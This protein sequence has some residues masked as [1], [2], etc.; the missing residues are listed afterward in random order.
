VGAGS[1]RV[2]DGAR[3]APSRA[4]PAT[5]NMAAAALWACWPEHCRFC[6]A[7]CCCLQVLVWALPLQR[8]RLAQCVTRPGQILPG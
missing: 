5:C 7:F 2:A 1:C 8:V 4:R 3:A 6:A